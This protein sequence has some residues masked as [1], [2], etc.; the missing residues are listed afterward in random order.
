[1]V[2]PRLPP[3]SGRKVIDAARKV[4][5]GIRG[6]ETK[7]DALIARSFKR[8]DRT[9]TRNTK[10]LTSNIL[11]ESGKLSPRQRAVL[12]HKKRLAALRKRKKDSKTE[13]YD[14]F[15]YN[16]SDTK[17]KEGGMYRHGT[18]GGKHSDFGSYFG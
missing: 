4:K 1:M 7:H 14:P 5:T 3:G 16:M 6:G 2:I 10:S 17:A 8:T 13:E 18:L 9:K 11:K 15:A 12:A